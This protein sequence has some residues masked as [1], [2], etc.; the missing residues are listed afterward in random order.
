M[1]CSQQ[2]CVTTTSYSLQE[3]VDN[4]FWSFHNPMHG[5]GKLEMAD[6]LGAPF[7]S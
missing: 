7:F 1:A 5:H 6:R 4:D 3:V 2:A